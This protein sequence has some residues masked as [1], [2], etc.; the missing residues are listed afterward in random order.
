MTNIYLNKFKSEPVLGALSGDTSSHDTTT[1]KKDNSN[2]LDK[3][4]IDLPK[5]DTILEKENLSSIKESKLIK[6]RFKDIEEKWKII[7]KKKPKDLIKNLKHYKKEYKKDKKIIE[8]DLKKI[9]NLPT[10][11]YKHL[12]SK[13][14]V[15]KEGMFNIVST[16][17]SEDLASYSKMALKYYEIIKPYLSSDDKDE[18]IK[19]LKGTW[20]KF[21]E[22]A[23]YPQFE[24]QKIKLNL[25]DNKFKSCDIVALHT[26]NKDTAINATIV[27]HTKLVKI[28]KK[29][30][31]KKDIILTIDSKIKDYKNIKNNKFIIKTNL[32][33]EIKKALKD[34]IKQKISKFKAKLKTKLEEKIRKKLGNLSA[35]EFNEYS[36]LL[37]DTTALK[38]RLKSE[39]KKRL[40]KELA[41]QKAKLKAKAKK[42][43]AKQ[44]ARLKQ[45]AEKEKQ[46]AKKKLEEK[47][48]NKFKSFF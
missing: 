17:I 11:D 15:D 37:K 19:R 24:I 38:A 21:K 35:K 43:L 36:K 14:T 42:E 2:I 48:K 13:Y 41:K 3:V 34:K 20:I 5:I 32:D 26:I 45:K 16:Y 47:L 39:A 33:N 29:L 46:K 44:K 22:D 25:V 6:Q 8:A 31:I 4:K 7:S 30:D 40:K 12:L 23:F 9:K 27:N 1:S 28:V 10:A 18:E